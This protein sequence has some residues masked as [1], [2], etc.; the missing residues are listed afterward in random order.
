LQKRA[1][2]IRRCLNAEQGG[3][4][5]QPSRL[6]IISLLGALSVISPF[7]IDM[8]LPAYAQVAADFAVP[9]ATVSLTLSSYFIGM[10]LG[11][12]FYGPLLD[13]FGRK[14]PLYAGLGLFMLA[15]VACALAPNIHALVA[16]RFVQALGGCVAGV[17]SLAMV[18]DFFPVDESAKILSRLFLFIAVSPLLAPTVG[19]AVALA[20]GW[21]TVF[22]LLAAIVTVILALIAFLLPEGHVPDASISLKPLPI[23]REYL[24]ILRHPRFATY[25]FSGAFSF[26]GL[27]TYVAGSPI[28]FMENFHLSARTYSTI[29]ALLA[30]GFIGGS[31]LNVVLLR[32]FS[33]EQLF[34][35]LLIAQVA[36]GAVFMLGAYAGWY[37]LGATL[38]LFFCFLSCVGLTY[39]NA[40]A[41]ALRPFSKNAG[42]A[43]ALLGF[44][45]L[46][47]G[48]VISTG[49]S[50]STSHTGFPIIAIMAVT[51]ALGLA[52]LLA[53]RKRA[54]ASPLS[55]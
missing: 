24:A 29:F 30:M 36:V 42:S 10:A 22:L 45:Q 7:A 27:F 1:I 48:S 12:V 41:L 51:A 37:G 3:H 38:A 21:K 43:A 32:R 18:R 31:Q 28:I 52:I 26:A 46:G 50:L 2:R 55:E 35:R 25:A 8:Y 15:S 40:A 49:I 4:A 5:I 17:A 9:S 39:P 47:V 11:Q 53:G 34:L 13:R 16:L 20:M 19:G 54:H 44:L 23:L 6:F 14:K 33:S